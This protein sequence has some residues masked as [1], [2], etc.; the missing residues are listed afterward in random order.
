MNID[1][2]KQL[3]RTLRD[4]LS[5]VAQNLEL[6]ISGIEFNTNPQG[7][8]VTIYLDGDSG[9]GIDKCS[10]FTRNASPILDVEDPIASAYNLEVSS[11]GYNRLIE[12]PK[13]FKR[14]ETFKIRV[15]LTDKKKKID[16]VLI[17]SNEES[18]VLKSDVNPRT[19]LYQDCSSVRL[20]PTPEQYAQMAPNRNLLTGED[21]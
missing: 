21:E 1:T 8:S 9:V 12:L 11:P 3:R 19:I 16:G 17:S 13:D 4:I 14:F 10:A 18:F 5:P 20:L 6:Y 2:Q 7:L 15:K